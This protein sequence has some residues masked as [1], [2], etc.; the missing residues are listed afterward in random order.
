MRRMERTSPTTATPPLRDYWPRRFTVVGLC[1]LSTFIC[2]IDRVNISFAI[3]PMAQ[4]FGWDKTTQGIVLSSF[5]YGY[6]ATQILGGWLAD[7]FGGKAVLGIGVVWWSLFTLLTPPAAAVSIAVLFGARVL[8]GLGE[9]LNFPAVLS[10]FGRWV[11][12]SEKSRAGTL[13]Y[14]GIPLGTVA[15]VLLTPLVIDAW[16][17][18]MVFYLYGL[19]GFVWYAAWQLRV[20]SS[21]EEHPSIH[22]AELARIRENA[23]DATRVERVPWRAL[24]SK[25]PVWALIVNHFCANWGFYIV[26]TWLPTYFNEAL[27]VDVESLGAYTFLPWVVMFVMGNFAGW[28]A[29]AL[30]RRGVSVTAVRKGMQSVGF[31]LPAGLFTLIGRIETPEAGMLLMIGA[32]GFGAFTL[33]GFAVNHLDIGPRYAGTLLGLSNTAGTIPG[34]VGV[35]LTGYMLQETGSWELV[36]GVAAG[37]YVFGALVWLL[38]STGRRVLD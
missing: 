13:T 8:M 20:T 4:E 37:V 29:D 38:F 22:P 2:Y 33:A 3:I 27:G 35:T 14:T 21:P 30:V 25:G 24:L 31:L 5:F 17:W 18:R 23:P 6:L 28:L 34:I 36:F 7:R 12:Q 19:L 1:F 15:A 16:D 11:P 10:L 32:L 26:L 9:G